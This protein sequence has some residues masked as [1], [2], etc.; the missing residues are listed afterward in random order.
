MRRVWGDQ[1]DG[2]AREQLAVRFFDSFRRRVAVVPRTLSVSDVF[3]VPCSHTQGWTLF[4]KKVSRGDD[5]HPH[6][7]GAHRSLFNHDG[8]LNDWGIHHFHLGI[9]P[10][11]KNQSLVERTGPVVIGYVTDEIFYAIGIYD[12]H[13]APWSKPELV[14]ILHRNWPEV[15]SQFK[16]NGFTGDSLSE[17]Q[18]GHLRK[19]NCA[20]FVEVSDGTVYMPMGGFMSGVGTDM[21]AQCQADIW[22]TEIEALQKDCENQ[23]KVFVEAL[24][25]LG[26]TVD[27]E[28]IGRLILVDDGYALMFPQYGNVL[29]LKLADASV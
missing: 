2:V 20:I 6:L 5:L 7:S 10:Q 1:V 22:H 24:H 15:I 18:R 21:Q 3:N 14:E 4:V 25:E 12:H 13:P 17:Y 9:K 28:L 11:V 8:L 19:K 23:V 27:G 29:G 16:V 26:H